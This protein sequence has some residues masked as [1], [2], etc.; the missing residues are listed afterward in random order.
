MI[1]NID[2]RKSE[3]YTLSIRLTADGFCFS[4]ASPTEK[5]F[6]PN[7][8][9]EIDLLLSE[10]GN[11]KK[12]FKQTEW[13]NNPFGQVN[14]IVENTRHLLMPL[15]YFDDEQTEAIF[16]HSFCQAENEV[17]CYNILPEENMVMLFGMDE[18]THDFLTE[19]Y[20]NAKFYAKATTLVRYQAKE[21]KESPHTLFVDLGKTATTLI[22]YEKGQ[23]LLCNSYLSLHDTDIAYY[24]L[25]CWK[26]LHLDQE[27]D[28]LRLTGLTSDH[29]ELLHVLPNYLKQVKCVEQSEDLDFKALVP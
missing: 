4:L 23:L 12:I 29:A 13:L 6:F 7:W 27:A 3:H 20:P 18:S 26:N 28:E 21:E 19:Q 8:E 25:S 15:A 2:F 9:S 22:A 16:Y 17:V 5:K 11:L 14:I 10:C 24:I 1:E